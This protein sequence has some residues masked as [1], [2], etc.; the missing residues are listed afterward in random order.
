LTIPN[1]GFKFNGTKWHGSRSNGIEREL[2]LGGIL[3]PLKL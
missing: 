3:A 2:G 1:D